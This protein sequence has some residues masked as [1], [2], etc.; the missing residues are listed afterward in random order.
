MVTEC[1]QRLIKFFCEENFAIYSKDHAPW[2]LTYAVIDLFAVEA[3][4]QELTSD[5]KGKLLD[6]IQEFFSA[7]NLYFANESQVMKKGEKSDF[8]TYFVD[9]MA[10]SLNDLLCKIFG[11][12]TF[13]C[14]E[15]KY[16]HCLARVCCQT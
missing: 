1:I 8:R 16:I 6:S 11:F 9:K 3:L 4:H 15:F 2:A 10:Y 5:D 13:F 7:G 14:S 12:F